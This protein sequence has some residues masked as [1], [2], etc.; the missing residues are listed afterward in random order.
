MD[1]QTRAALADLQAQIDQLAGQLA[2]TSQDE[3]LVTQQP[4]TVTQLDST[5]LLDI[6]AWTPP[7]AGGEV[8]GPLDTSGFLY[9]G[10]ILGL[11]PLQQGGAAQTAGVYF[12]WY[13]DPATSENVG[14]LTFS[15][16]NLIPSTAQLRLPNLGPYVTFEADP[17]TGACPLAAKLFGTNRPYTLPLVPPDPILIDESNIAIAA[18]HTDTW[19]PDDYYAGPTE[20]YFYA[21]G[22]ITWNMYGIDNLG[23]NWP[24]A[25]G[26]A[27]GRQVNW[28]VLAPPGAWFITVSNSDTLAAHQYNLAVMA[29]FTGGA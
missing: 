10:G 23:Q 17:V 18:N 21:N 13:L 24:I 25:G 5:M 19:Y 2:W 3:S 6:P 16:S 15:L 20:I 12:T 11:Q 22:E 7:A 26:Y 14:S 28:N 9:L 29:S 4:P 27:G 1:S 8:W